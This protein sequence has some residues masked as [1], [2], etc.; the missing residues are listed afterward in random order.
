MPGIVVLAFMLLVSFQTFARAADSLTNAPKLAYEEPLSLTG[1]IYSTDSDNR[2]ILFKFKRDAARSGATLKVLRQYS[3][4][5]GKLAS[6]ERVEY[7]GNNLVSFELEELQ[8]GARGS[9]RIDRTAATIHFEYTTDTRPGSVGKKS[10]E[11]LQPDTLV[12]DMVGPFLVR[13]WDA[14]IGG[15]ELKC[16]YIAAQRRETVGFT[17]TKTSET[18]VD[19]HPAIIVKMAPT[20]LIIRALV[21]PLYFTIQKEAPHHVLQY[22]GRTTPKLKVGN[23]WKDLDALTVFDWKAP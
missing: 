16:R 2:Q 20:S 12:G 1:T 6:V 15:R 9:A 8:I 23:K 22:V 14:L 19:G 5:D 21:D 10:S 3:Y 18:T 7:Q 4:P 13:N 17:F 11:P